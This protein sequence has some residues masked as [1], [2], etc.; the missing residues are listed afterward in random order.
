[1]EKHENSYSQLLNQ[2]EKKAKEFEIHLTQI[3]T[4][5]SELLA[6]SGNINKAMQEMLKSI[7]YS[8]KKHCT[9]CYVRERRVCLIPC[10]HIFCTNCAD[11][12]R[13]SNKCFTCRGTIENMVRIYM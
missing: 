1:M 6:R 13:R 2:I 11:R 7:S 12:S 3:Q 5:N 8:P 9:V 10:G 4:L